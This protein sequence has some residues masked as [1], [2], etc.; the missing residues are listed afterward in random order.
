[1]VSKL[2]AVAK[3]YLKSGQL[4]FDVCTSIP[5]AW[6]EFGSR[7]ANCQRN[8]LSGKMELSSSSDDGNQVL[9]ECGAMANS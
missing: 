7:N 3:D 2:S 4:I 6:I 8:A 9:S 1:M 5:V